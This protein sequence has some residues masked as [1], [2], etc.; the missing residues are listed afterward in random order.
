MHDDPHQGNNL[1]LPGQQ[2]LID[3]NFKAWVARPALQHSYVGPREAVFDRTAV[4][5][6]GH[7]Q[8]VDTSTK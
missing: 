4:P 6:K 8:N 7:F 5:E 2:Y 1:A 3:T